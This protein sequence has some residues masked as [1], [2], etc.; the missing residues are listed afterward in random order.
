MG[1]IHWNLR[2]AAEHRNLNL[3]TVFDPLL[4]ASINKATTEEYS[5]AKYTDFKC[6]MSDTG[7]LFGIDY[8]QEA[9]EDQQ[10]QATVEKE[11]DV[12]SDKEENDT[13]LEVDA[14]V[15][16]ELA[17]MMDESKRSKA[18]SSGGKLILREK[19]EEPSVCIHPSIDTDSPEISGMTEPLDGFTD[20]ELPS[21]KTQVSYPLV[22]KISNLF[23]DF[24]LCSLL[25]GESSKKQQKAQNLEWKS[26]P[27]AVANQM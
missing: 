25:Q 15:Q 10:H 1:L 5:I 12:L 2:R 20:M 11:S 6:N 17:Q 26:P 18:T 8:K 22:N 27:E 14:S 3:P 16:I 19:L 7:E 24:D 9:A 21:I 4:T 23:Q 13:V